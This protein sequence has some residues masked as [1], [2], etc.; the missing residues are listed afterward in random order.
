[1]VIFN[2]CLNQQK[3]VSHASLTRVLMFVITVVQI[4]E[5]YRFRAVMDVHEQ[6]TFFFYL[7]PARRR[8]DKN[9]PYIFI[10]FI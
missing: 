5:F 8:S 7:Y 3:A 4:I 6:I 9:A 2:L 1:M 10:F